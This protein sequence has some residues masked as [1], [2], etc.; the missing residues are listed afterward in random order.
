MQ[1]WLLPLCA[2]AFCAAITSSAQADVR[3]GTLRCNVS[4]GVSYI[5]GSQKGLNCVFYS[6]QGYT[7]R[8]VGGFGRLGIDLGYTTGGGLDAALTVS[9]IQLDW[10]AP[11]RK[12]VRKHR[13]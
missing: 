5:V 4:P 8:Y 2:A 12:R 9:G 7:E 10:V 1:K 11:H 13:S 6:A 3:V